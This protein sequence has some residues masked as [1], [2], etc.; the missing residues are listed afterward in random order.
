MRDRG[1]R[2]GFEATERELLSEKAA[3]LRRIAGRLEELLAELG[4]MRTALSGGGPEH[5]GRL[6]SYRA[7]RE[8]A[9]RYRWYLEVQRE[10]VGLRRHEDL[11]PHYPIPEAGVLSTRGESR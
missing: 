3:A 9:R 11:E 7:V 6:A 1:L 10:A 2:D 5:E 4:R 8:E